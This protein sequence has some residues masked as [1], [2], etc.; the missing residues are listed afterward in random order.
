MNRTAG[1]G[2]VVTLA[3]FLVYLP[4]V[5]PT[6]YAGDAGELA[7]AAA[8]LGIAH[9]PGYP[10]WTLL[11]RLA[12]AFLPGEPAYGLG[13]LSAL[14]MAGAAGCV[15]SL[16]FVWTESLLVSAGMG[17][18]FAVS[19]GVWQS[20]VTTEVYAL[21]LLLTITALLVAVLARRG[22]PSLFALAAYLLGLG[23]ANHPFALLAG[24]PVLALALASNERRPETVTARVVRLPWMAA[25]FALG[26]TVYLVLPLRMAH[27]E[28]NWGG[29]HTLSGVWDHVMRAQ[30]GGLG[31]ASASASV[32]ARLRIFLSVLSH[33][34]LPPLWIAAV[35]G[36]VSLF[37]SGHRFRA[38]LLL[39]FFALA[40]PLTV[41]AIRYDDTALDR[42]VIAVFFLPAVLACTLM[43]GVGLGEAARLLAERL[44]EQPRAALVATAALALLL[45]A[46]LW[47]ANF[48]RCDRSRSTFA[49][50]YA[51][52]VLRE[53]PPD[54]RLFTKGDN[55]C[56]SLLYAH[57]IL[58]LRP[59]VTIVDR[60]LNLNVAAYGED[61]LPMTRAERRSARAAREAAFVFGEADRPVFLT[62]GADAA[63]FA[64]CRDE[65]AGYVA[66]LLR[67][68]ERAAPF[69]HRL[70]DDLAPI[71]PD[72]FLESHF[73]A[74]ALCREALWCVRTG[75]R[76]EARI[77]LG[78]AAEFAGRN[79]IVLRNIALVRLDLGDLDEAERLLLRVVEMEPENED[80]LYNLA[81]LCSKGERGAEA[82]EWFA[83]LERL[84]TQ[85]PEAPLGYAF[86]LL[87]AGRLEDAAERA[88]RALELAPE[89]ESAR[90]LARALERGLQLGGDAGVLEAQRDLGTLTT[91]GT[92]QLA[93][94]YLLRGNV[95]RATE[96]YREAAGED[97]QS[98][99]AAYGLGYGLL[100]AGRYAEAEASFRRVLELEPGSADGH[101]ALAFILAQTGD[102]LDVAE[103]LVTEALELDPSLAAY[104]N[105]TLGWV[106]FRAG[107]LEGALVA[108]LRAEG[109]LP[110]DDF[111]TRSEN[112]YH[113]GAVLAAMDRPD[114]A[115]D[116]FRRSVELAGDGLFAADRSARMRELGMEGGSS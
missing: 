70:R 27:A 97:P 18:V 42:S 50:D 13:L 48:A 106:R 64:G 81:V 114:E 116:R 73:A 52:T 85:Y 82:L 74:A 59:D 94:R 16:L 38:A 63:M 90:K 5:C 28:V 102:S 112:Q 32:A 98:I 56:F 69:E 89:L 91:E 37:R 92:L 46:F 75:K 44:R 3:S 115:R 51:T 35:F 67:P 17:L 21:N 23:V 22:R 53:L 105:D 9:P 68:G 30:Y 99:G 79:P 61:F 60:S 77:R 36:I 101:N 93:Q 78:K 109:E 65:P 10:L 95:A 29:V 20:A 43:A 26:L 33:S 110:R 58:G 12:V 86:E 103:R 6:I 107:A 41:A 8:T 34:F 71:D 24:P 1:V 88:R 96:L 49:A 104:W 76:V 84:E 80:A 19:R 47:E 108:L 45:P 11:G 4:T 54:A 40:G 25:A 55:E 15:A 31:E 7:A 66:Q 100:Q 72:D 2:V 111:A 14:A 87:R 113:L 83:R 62:E 57:R 39:L